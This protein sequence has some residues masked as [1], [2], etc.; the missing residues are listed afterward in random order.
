VRN[1]AHVPEIK[2]REPGGGVGELEDVGAT[3]G[4][5]DAAH[6]AQAGEAVDEIAQ[7]PRDG[8]GV[9]GGG[10][11]GEPDA[12]ADEEIA[13]MFGR[14]A[15]EH[16]EAEVGAERGFGVGAMALE[17]EQD[18]AAAS[19]KIEDARG[20]LRGD[21]ADKAPAPVEIESAA[22]DVVH[23]VV[24]GG[25]ASEHGA[26]GTGRLMGEIVPQG[27]VIGGVGGAGRGHAE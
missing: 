6:F 26:D 12:V 11:Q 7:A 17:G 4:A 19:G 15:L 3:A 5:Q 8:D 25:D 1:V 24:A 18:V 22:E 14:G 9:E 21:G 20:F 10:G 2:G 27:A 13:G 16:G 23:E